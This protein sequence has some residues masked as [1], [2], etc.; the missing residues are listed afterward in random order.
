[1]GEVKLPVVGGVNKRTLWIGGGAAIVLMGILWYRKKNTAVTRTDTGLPLDQ[2]QVDSGTTDAGA[3]GGGG[4]F[5][6]DQPLNTAGLPPA[7][8][9]L[10]DQQATQALAGVV[11]PGALSAALGLYLSGSAVTPDQTLLID[12]AIAVAGYPPVAGP[13]GY[14]P[15]IRTQAATGQTTPSAGTSSSGLTGTGNHQYTAAQYAQHAGLSLARFLQLNPSLKAGT[16]LAPHTQVRV[17][18]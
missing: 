13:N 1:M 5:A 2:S 18:A 15:A 17:A 10:W 3:G 11:D 16:V 8:N 14:P 7:S 6:A 4:V 9:P 12:Q